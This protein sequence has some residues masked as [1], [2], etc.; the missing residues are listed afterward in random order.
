MTA[1]RY[2]HTQTGY[3]ILLIAL[4]AALALTVYLMVVTNLNA[5]AVVV[6]LVL[7]V[8]LVVF[9]SLTVEV[10]REAV[11]VRFGL[12]LVRRLIPL[13]KVKAVTVVHNPWYYGWGI[14]YIGG[15]WLFNVSRTAAVEL[16]LETGARFRVGTDAPHELAQ[17][18]R[19]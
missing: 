4:G 1:G 6:A 18:L 15:G 11:A 19:S 7:A 13:S 17:A 16:R 10:G 12:G 3:L 5:I 2:R 8:L 9:S 14:R